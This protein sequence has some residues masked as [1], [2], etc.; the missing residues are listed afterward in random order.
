MKEIKLTKGK[1]AIVD[2]EDF[3]SLSQFKWHCSVGYAMRREY[4]SRK[5]LLMHRVILNPPEG[6]EPDHINGD[7]LDNRRCNLRISTRS[8]NNLNKNVQKNSSSGFKG[9]SW[10]KGRSKWRAYMG[11]AHIG[12]FNTKE[13]AAKAYDKKALEVF[14]EFAKLNFPT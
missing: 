13:E 8:E 7:R 6:K 4:P 11:G 1:V 10:K 12:H 2:D 14:G 3:E 9:V 5:I